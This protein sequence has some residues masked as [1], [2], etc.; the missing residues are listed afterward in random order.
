R[1]GQIE[2]GP[3]SG[4]V[5]AHL[6]LLCG[7]DRLENMLQ[8][9][10][11]LGCMAT[12]TL[13]VRQLLQDEN[14]IQPRAQAFAALLIVTLPTGIVESITTQTDYTCGFWLMCLASV[15]LAW[16]REPASRAYAAGFGAAL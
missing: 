5:Q 10:A 13:L 6:W 11:M 1:D 9:S 15:G 2:M 7:N 12:A 16:C 4:F 3:W 14:A 8:W